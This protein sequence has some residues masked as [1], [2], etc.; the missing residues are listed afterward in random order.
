[1]ASRPAARQAAPEIDI[2]AYSPTKLLKVC[3]CETNDKEKTKSIAD[4][5]QHL[6]DL[7]ASIEEPSRPDPSHSRLRP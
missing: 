5:E 6:A 2:V 4:A 1:M 7:T 3:W